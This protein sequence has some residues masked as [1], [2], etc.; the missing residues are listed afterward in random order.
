MPRQGVICSFC[1]RPFATTSCAVVLAPGAERK[2]RF[3][4]SSQSAPV[5]GGKDRRVP[6]TK[7]PRE[8]AAQPVPVPANPPPHQ[9]QPREKNRQ[10]ASWDQ[11]TGADSAALWWIGDRGGT[12]VLCVVGLQWGLAD[13]SDILV[14]QQWSRAKTTLGFR[15]LQR[16]LCGR[17]RVRLKATSWVA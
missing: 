10:A 5:E 15:R 7:R 14:G 2:C 12:P 16:R 17:L 4:F 11:L 1:A 8:E 6:E 9:D 13:I 3:D